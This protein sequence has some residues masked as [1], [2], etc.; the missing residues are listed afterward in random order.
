MAPIPIALCGKSSSMAT[1]FSDSM[2]PEYKVVHHFQSTGAVHKELPLLMSGKPFTPES[3]VGYESDAE[4]RRI[5][6]AVMV[7]AGFSEAELEDMRK[8]EGAEKLP[9]L[10]PDALK[11]AASTLS[12]PFLMDVIVRRVKGCLRYNGLEE[13]KEGDIKGGVWKF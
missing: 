13:G 5:P 4:K 10:F 2:M 1:S 6:R 8:V 11:T 7:G 3:D 9:W 12:G